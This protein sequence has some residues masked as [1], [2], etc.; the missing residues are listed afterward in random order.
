[1]LSALLQKFRMTAT[2]GSP[3]WS[4]KRCMHWRSH[5]DF[6]TDRG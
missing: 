6:A 4:K 3:F 2:C 1:M 5:A